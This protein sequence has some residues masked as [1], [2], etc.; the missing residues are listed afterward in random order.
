MEYIL[1]PRVG[2]GHR[3]RL[4]PEPQ[5]HHR[6]EDIGPPPLQIHLPPPVQPDTLRTIRWT[7]GH[8]ATIVEDISLF[9]P[10]GMFIIWSS[11]I[12]ISQDMIKVSMVIRE[13]EEGSLNI[14]IYMIMMMMIS[15]TW[16][17]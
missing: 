8:T 1:D 12:F 6:R 11:Y 16:P 17:L 7:T 3:R 2:R 15:L 10:A 5:R 14:N 9:S 4:G 13:G